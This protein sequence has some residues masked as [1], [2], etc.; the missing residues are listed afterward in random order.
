MLQSKH[1]QYCLF[2]NHFIEFNKTGGILKN[3]E[4]NVGIFLQ[5]QTLIS[6][7]LETTEFFVENC[8]AVKS[9]IHVLKIEEQY[10]ILLKKLKQ[11]E[12]DFNSETF[13]L[14]NETD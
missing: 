4:N 10:S 2:L 7:P 5:H 9:L 12:N 3:V 1:K 13:A 11:L 14:L 8:L 6:A